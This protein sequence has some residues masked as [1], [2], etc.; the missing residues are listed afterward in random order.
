MKKLIVS[1]L[2]I[3]S[4][5]AFSQST[6]KTYKSG[7]ATITVWENQKTGVNGDYTERNYEVNKIYKKGNQWKETNNFTYSELLKLRAIIDKAI[8]EEEIKVD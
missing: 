7:K 1:G 4:V 5:S 2:M 6:S 8:L 3:I